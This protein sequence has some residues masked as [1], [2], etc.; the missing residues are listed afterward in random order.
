[1]PRRRQQKM[2]EVS[3]ENSNKLSNKWAEITIK[4]YKK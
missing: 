2:K 4:K 1:M 3:D